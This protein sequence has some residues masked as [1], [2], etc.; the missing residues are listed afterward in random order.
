M[1]HRTVI[2]SSLNASW[3]FSTRK[4]IVIWRNLKQL[5]WLLLQTNE[6]LAKSRLSWLFLQD[7]PKCQKEEKQDS[8]F[9]VTK[10]LSVLW[11]NLFEIV[12]FLQCMG[13]PILGQ[14]KIEDGNWFLISNESYIP[15]N[16]KGYC[17]KPM[18]YSLKMATKRHNFW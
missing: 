3:Q 14:L 17:G 16:Y 9:C 6:H 5:I 8:L 12:L 7:Q 1:L 13:S 4:Y 2:Y 18:V 10:Y 11:W 15:L